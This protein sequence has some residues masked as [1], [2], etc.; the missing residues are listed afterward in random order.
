MRRARADDLAMFV[1]HL[2]VSP[3]EYRSLTLR[4]RD[5][6]LSAHNRRR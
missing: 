1:V 6:I 3:T 5:A 2:G 4:E